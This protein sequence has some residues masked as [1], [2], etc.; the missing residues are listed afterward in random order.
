MA[1]FAARNLAGLALV[2]GGVAL[3]LVAAAAEGRHAAQAASIE[4]RAFAPVCPPAATA[5]APT[6]VRPPPIPRP[7]AVSPA[8]A[9]AAPSA[10]A[11]ASAVPALAL[12][13]F[14]AAVTLPRE[15]IS[16]VMAYANSR[17]GDRGKIV[18]EG[19]ADAPGADPKTEGV[20]RGRAILVRSLFAQANVEAERITVATGDVANE[21]TLAMQ[22]RIR[23]GK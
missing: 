18:I 9:S 6:P 16:R 21:P 20:A 10:S 5:P 13:K 22:V 11:P 8:S 15:E 14:T 17:R 3:V 7:S 19:F 1:S 2:A 12:F 4:A 23:E